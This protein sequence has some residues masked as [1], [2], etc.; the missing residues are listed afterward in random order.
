MAILHMKIM[1]W[2]HHDVGQL[3][4]TGVHYH[5]TWPGQ[6]TTKNSQHE[7]SND[8]SNIKVISWVTKI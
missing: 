5:S 7:N 3:S 6:S 8:H 1:Y 4:S 2:H